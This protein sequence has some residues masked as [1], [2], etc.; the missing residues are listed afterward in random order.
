MGNRESITSEPIT[1]DDF[2]DFRLINMEH[3]EVNREKLY[4]FECK[5]RAEPDVLTYILSMHDDGE[6]F[7]LHTQ[8]DDIWFR[9][10]MRQLRMLEQIVNRE[11]T[12]GLLEKDISEAKNEDDLYFV[13]YAIWELEQ[14]DLTDDQW[15]QIG[16]MMDAKERELTN[17]VIQDEKAPVET[18]SGQPIPGIGANKQRMPKV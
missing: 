18:V 9:M 6:H 7:S 12:L 4:T 8:N 17:P 5:V 15:E 10:D 2:T 13:N 1:A 3:D 14:D 16:Q 11:A